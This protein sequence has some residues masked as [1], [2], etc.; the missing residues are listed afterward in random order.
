MRRTTII[1]V[2]V[3]F[4]H[5]RELHND[6]LITPLITMITVI[7]T[8]QIPPTIA[9]CAACCCQGAVCRDDTRRNKVANTAGSG[10]RQPTSQS[11]HTRSGPDTGHPR[12]YRENV[13]DTF[14]GL[15]LDND[16]TN[17]AAASNYEL[18]ASNG[19]RIRTATQVTFSD[20]TVVRFMERMPKGEA[21]RRALRQVER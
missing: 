20:G 1:A 17:T 15:W 3:F 8:H 11:Q 12:T 9:A 13:V 16:M 14:A 6:R 19:R 2:V 7:G 5:E 18:F 10:E 21:I 4:H